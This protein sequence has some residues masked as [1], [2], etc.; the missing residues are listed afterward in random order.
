MH[1]DELKNK[2]IAILWFGLEGKSTLNFLLQQKIPFKNITILDIND[3]IETS[4][5]VNKITWKEYLNNL[6]KYDIIFK[7]SGVPINKELLPHEDKLITQ[8]QFFFDNYK[9]KVITITASKGKSTMSTLIYQMLKDAGKKV[10]LVWNIWTPVLDEIDLKEEYDYIAYEVSSYML[11]NLKKNSY[12]SVLGSIFPEHLDRHGSMETYVQA[13]LNILKNSEVNIVQQKTIKTYNLNKQYEH[14]I[15][16]GK[17][18]TFTRH[19]EIFYNANTPLFPTKNRRILGD[20]NLENI[21]AAI[22]VGS[23]LNIPITSIEKTIATFKWL[24]HRMEYIGKY[25]NIDFYDD[26]ISTTPES[27]IQAIKTLGKK[28]DTIFLGGTDRGY[29]FHELISYLKKYKIK[30]IVLFSPSGQRIKELIKDNKQYTILETNDMKTA[31]KFAFQ[32][33]EKGKICLLST[34]SPSYSIRKN[35][36]EKGDL[37]KKFIKFH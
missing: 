8:T 2:N 35:F 4:K 24:P 6:D 28:I 23:M 7:S 13:K 17:E 36:E 27:T 1:I 18:G 22:A 12:I 26:A 11:H 37:F 30:N 10:K 16:Y 32:H 34:A 15:S 9:G 5:I 33:T 3:N 20:H 29:N 31:V 25:E 21:C 14:L 19:G